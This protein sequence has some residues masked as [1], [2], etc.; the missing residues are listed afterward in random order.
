MQHCVGSLFAPLKSGAILLVTC[1]LAFSCREKGTAGMG[2]TLPTREQVDSEEAVRRAGEKNNSRGPEKCDPPAR[3]AAM[4]VA[5][6]AD[7]EATSKGAG[8]RFLGYNLANWLVLGER[9][10]EETKK[11]GKNAPKPEDEKKAVVA[12]VA[13]AK[14]DVFGV[15][16]IG[17]KD[18]LIDVQTRLKAA[19]L[20]LPHLHYTGGVDPTRHLGLLSR[21]PIVGTAKPTDTTYQI[22]GKDYGIQRGI[23]DATVKTPDGR[24]WRC[25]G[26]HL[27]SKR[28][29]E[30]GDQN[31]M[32]TREAELLRRHLDEIFKA[33]PAVRLIAYGDYNDT[34]MTN[35][36]KI[37][38][39]PYNSPRA[40]MPIALKDSR[41]EFWTHY[42][43]REDVYSRIDFIMVSEAMRK[44]VINDQCRILEAKD[45]KTASDHRPLLGVFR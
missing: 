16:E 30:D 25:V 14:P 31:E 6:G 8:L 40:L 44:D 10:D 4:T 11:S 21:F 3:T 2:G 36:L 9:Y 12:V 20:D 5:S 23:L 13:G 17:T 27:K 42:W 15:C 35:P 32:R 1:L 37:V 38:Q 29:V 24:L 26:V 45:W 43:G 39:G 33:D 41:G 34:R 28:E 22:G 7:K 19:G 18:D